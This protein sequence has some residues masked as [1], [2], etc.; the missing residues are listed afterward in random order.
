[1]K[2][3]IIFGVI[4]SFLIIFTASFIL[5]INSAEAREAT[6][7]C[8]TIGKNKDRMIKISYDQA[9]GTHVCETTLKHFGVDFT[10]PD[11]CGQIA[12]LYLTDKSCQPPPPRDSDGDGFIDEIDRCP[13]E[14]S[15]TNNGCPPVQ[16]PS[17]QSEEFA[18]SS[19]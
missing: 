8:A 9:T 6:A 19:R 5:E 13:R 1:M 11:R 4:F 12:G 18:A 7:H 10:V 3:K 16:T 17:T 14:S 15:T 2:E